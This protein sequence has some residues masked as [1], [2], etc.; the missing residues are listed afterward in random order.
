MTANKLESYLALYQVEYKLICAL[1]VD[2]PSTVLGRCLAFL[3]LYEEDIRWALPVSNI[4]GWAYIVVTKEEVFLL[5]GLA[6]E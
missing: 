4:V 6:E 5:M 2:L 1:T 3:A